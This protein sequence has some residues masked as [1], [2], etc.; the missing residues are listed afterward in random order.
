MSEVRRFKFIDG[1]GNLSHEDAVLA[2]DY[3][4]VVAEKNKIIY[5]LHHQL[6]VA[7][8]SLETARRVR[9]AQLAF[10]SDVDY[11]LSNPC[12]LHASDIVDSIRTSL[13]ELAAIEKDGTK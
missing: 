13:E 2:S 5:E 1:A 4:R 3:E 12:G 6:A 9:A 11:A 8:L 7:S 10:I